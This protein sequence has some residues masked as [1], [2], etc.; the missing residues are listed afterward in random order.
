MRP[1]PGLLHPK[2]RTTLRRVNFRGTCWD[3]G[4]T[5]VS[6]IKQRNRGRHEEIAHVYALYFA[7][8]VGC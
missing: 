3:A 2:T 5:F 6:Q 8:W 4:S 7:G 1:G